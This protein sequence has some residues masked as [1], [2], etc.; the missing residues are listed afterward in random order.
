MRRSANTWYVAMVD[1]LEERLSIWK[2]RSRALDV[3][4]WVPR[5][6]IWKLVDGHWSDASEDMLP[7]YALVSSRLGPRHIEKVLDVELLTNGKKCASISYTEVVNLRYRQRRAC[8]KLDHVFKSGQEVMV[9]EDARSS[10]SGMRGI[11]HCPLAVGCGYQ[12]R[13]TILLFESRN[14]TVILPY[15]HLTPCT[16]ENLLE[17]RESSERCLYL[18]D[19][20]W[21]G[22][23]AR[24]IRKRNEVVC[25]K[26]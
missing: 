14:P 3:I 23:V 24:L 15:D 18:L 26:T 12:A 19:G 25:G 16:I 21:T 5:E 11:F 7:G 22:S 20:K 6:E 1:D 10:Y 9:R 17:K 4:V 13:V 2:R 8:Y